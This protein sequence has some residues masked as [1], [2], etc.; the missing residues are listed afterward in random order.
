MV[1]VIHGISG[2]KVRTG[3]QPVTGPLNTGHHAGVTDP[4]SPANESITSKIFSQISP[5]Y[6]TPTPAP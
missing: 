6:L 3:R 1:N 4:G 2:E 5:R